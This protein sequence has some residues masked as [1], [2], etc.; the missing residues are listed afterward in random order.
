MGPRTSPSRPRTRGSSPSGYPAP[1]CSCSR[2]PVTCTTRSGPRRPMPL[3]WTSYG[4]TEM[5]EAPQEVVRLAEERA[6]A[7]A[8]KDFAKADTLRDRIAD[9]GWTVVDEPGGF[10]LERERVEADPPVR[11]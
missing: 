7:R 3:S 6:A 4:G 8:S 2:G 10:H 5:P 11:R 9:S 1:S